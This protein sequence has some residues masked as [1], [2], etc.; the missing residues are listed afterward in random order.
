MISLFLVSM[1]L[2]QAPVVTGNGAVEMPQKE[3]RGE[4]ARRYAMNF[5]DQIFDERDI[6]PLP[7]LREGKQ[8]EATQEALKRGT[9]R[10][11][12]V[13]IVVQKDGKVNDAIITKR[14]GDGLDESV[15]DAV[16][17]WRFDPPMKD[18]QPVAVFL[19]VMI[20]FNIGR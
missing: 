15:L 16:K 17:K 13:L 7:P 9:S 8:A 6:Q 5:T 19:Q 11:V 2:L 10:S 18:G 1:L 4:L 14:A 12:G 3:A 20:N